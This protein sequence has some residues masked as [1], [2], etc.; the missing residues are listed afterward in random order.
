MN[1]KTV[2]IAEAGV[3]HNGSLVIAKQLI[4]AA[5]DA[6]ADYVK[7]QTFVSKLVVT[8]NAKQA[9]Y[10]SK[11]T[12]LAESQ[13]DMIAKLELTQENHYELLNYASEKGIK[14]FST[15]FDLSSIK[16]LHGLNLDYFKIPSGEITNLPYL[17]LIGSYNRPILLSTGMSSF[18]D[19][20][21][22]LNVI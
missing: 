11:N 4:D 16:F 8:R 21:K 17:R 19:I 22:A 9:E 15:P 7:F 1:N 20:D 12:R 3:N 10:Q 14:F 2:I 6:E 18:S 5:A 13:Y